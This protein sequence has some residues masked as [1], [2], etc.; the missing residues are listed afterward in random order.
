MGEKPDQNQALAGQPCTVSRL[1]EEP[2]VAVITRFFEKRVKVRN[3]DVALAFDLD[4]A[5][6]AQRAYLTAHGFQRQ[7]QIL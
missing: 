1:R 2:T 3:N 5:L 4:H 6:F 7:T